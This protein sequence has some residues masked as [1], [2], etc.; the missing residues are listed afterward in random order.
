MVL[1]SI[2]PRLIAAC[3]RAQI[4]GLELHE[5][6]ALER[7]FLFLLCFRLTV[8]REEYDAC[9]AGLS[10]LRRPPDALQPAHYPA[11]HSPTHAAHA[12]AADPACRPP[13]PSPCNRPDSAR[14]CAR[15]VEMSEPAAAAEQTPRM[16]V[17]RAPAAAAGAAA[18]GAAAEAMAAEGLAKLRALGLRSWDE[19]HA[20]LHAPHA[21]PGP[22]RG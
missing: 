16:D 8:S 6:N 9:A 12:A 11:S 7:E 1:S 14:G 15:D 10:A 22:A 21:P 3:C 2:D 19:P 20:P 17:E 5:L 18:E 13:H 4:A